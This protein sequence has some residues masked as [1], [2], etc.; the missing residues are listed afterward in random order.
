MD[1]NLVFADQYEE[2]HT[3]YKRIFEG[4]HEFVQ[5]KLQEDN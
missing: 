5:E 3:Q 2:D 1:H 4:N